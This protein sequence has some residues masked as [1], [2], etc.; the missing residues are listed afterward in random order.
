L[1]LTAGAT[2]KSPEI[3]KF[4]AIFIV[5]IRCISQDV[6]LFIRIQILDFHAAAIRTKNLSLVAGVIAG[7]IQL[8]SH[9][10]PAAF[11]TFFPVLAHTTNRI[12]FNF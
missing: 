6:S 3:V 2:K 12:D 8:G 9:T 5:K 1:L 11:L 7:S 4:P 10:P